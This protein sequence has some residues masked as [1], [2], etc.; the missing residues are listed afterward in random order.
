[1]K[2]VIE[3]ETFYIPIDRGIDDIIPKSSFDIDNLKDIVVDEE[4][5]YTLCRF[6]E[7]K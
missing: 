4:V 1:M 6:D 3:K 2:P 7:N 5:S